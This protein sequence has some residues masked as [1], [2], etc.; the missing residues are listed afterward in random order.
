MLARFI[1]WRNRTL[2]GVVLGV[3][4][5]SKF[6][7]V[8]HFMETL[9]KCSSFLSGDVYFIDFLPSEFALE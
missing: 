2:W 3:L 1:N 6:W 9:F 4:M 5:A 7:H 8:A